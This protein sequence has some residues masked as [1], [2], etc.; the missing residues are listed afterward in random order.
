MRYQGLAIC[1]LLLPHRGAAQADAF[2]KVSVKVGSCPLADSVQGPLQGKTRK[3]AALRRPDSPILLLD[4]SSDQVGQGLSS[5]QVRFS[6][7]ASPAPQGTTPG[8][9]LTLLIPG[10]AGKRILA[11]KEAPPLTL[12]LAD[13]VLLQPS[14]VSVGTYDGPPSFVMAPVSAQLAPN[15]LLAVVKSDSLAIR[16]GRLLLRPSPSFRERLR[17]SYRVTMCGYDSSE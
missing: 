3:I 8:A 1:L 12:E 6:L 2:T 15:S 17:D 11:A 16:A 10:D 13:S 9:Y 5:P 14:K 4:V 7:R